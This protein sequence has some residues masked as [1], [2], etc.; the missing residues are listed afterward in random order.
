MGGSVEDEG[1][2]DG[3]HWLQEQEEALPLVFG[4]HRGMGDVRC[5]AGKGQRGTRLHGCGE[6]KAVFVRACACACACRA[7]MCTKK[8]T[9]RT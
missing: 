1:G 4:A 5:M 9:I 3:G 7:S 8:A 2:E 6:S